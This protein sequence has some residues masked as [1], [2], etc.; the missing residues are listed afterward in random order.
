MNSAVAFN[1]PLINLQLNGTDIP[2]LQEQAA[3]FSLDIDKAEVGEDIHGLRMLCLY[4]LK[5]AAAYM[6]HAHVLGQYDNYGLA[7]NIAIRYE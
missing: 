6:E 5:G 1:H 3:Q 2:T 4:G 7:W